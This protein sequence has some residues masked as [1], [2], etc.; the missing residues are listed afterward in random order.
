M[1]HT[2]QE[3][4][5]PALF[6]RL[7]GGIYL[8]MALTGALCLFSCQDSNMK[9]SAQTPYIEA[10]ARTE[11]AQ[12]RPP[13]MVESESGAPTI[14]VAVLKDA[15]S[16]RIGS[17]S[18]DAV[19]LNSAGQE[20]LRVPANSEVQ[21]D[22]SAGAVASISIAP[23]GAAG[24]PA[25]SQSFTES[26]LR[27]ESSRDGGA[28]SLKLNGQD[29][30][31]RI[32]LLRPSAQRGITALARLDLEEYLFGV[33]GGEVPFE[34]WHAEAL[35]AQAIASRSYAYFQIKN[36]AG[37]PYDVEST[38]MSQVFKGG[39]RSNPILA[40]AIDATRGQVLTFN[41]SPFCAYF[42]STCG[43]HTENGG[44]VFPDQPQA[45]VL[46]G[47]NC[48]YCTQSPNYKWR[49][50]IGKDVLTE[51]LRSLAP[52]PPLGQIRGVEFYDAS[53]VIITQSP[54]PRRVATVRIRHAYGAFDLNG[55]VFR[56]A[57]GARDLKSLLLYQVTERSDALD[58][59][60][61]GFGHGVGMCQY[62]SQG[63]AQ[64][65]QTHPT[66]LGMYY[67]GASLTRM[68]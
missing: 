22:A 21:F 56:L 66:I 46:R 49:W 19:V 11:T 67:P 44:A 45:R 23:L 5:R 16:L 29:I 42:H 25:S 52:N 54:T 26:S 35:K 36:N 55:N 2:I 7:R 15:K 18:S 32:T 41:G 3:R 48:P 17:G 4:R 1:S 64:S 68:Y 40:Q 33:L 30:A 9:T 39:Y 59:S 34:R 63:M 12:R 62:G 31:P 13:I 24:H 60:G 50:V 57:V 47:V 10:P 43:G 28:Q 6:E 61:G 53:G 20:L 27:I 8:S 58:V 51:K 37:E 65:G 38:V 14:R